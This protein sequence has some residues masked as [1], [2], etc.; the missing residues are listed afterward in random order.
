MDSIRFIEHRWQTQ[1]PKDIY[2]SK[3]SFFVLFLF[4]VGI[5]FTCY[6]KWFDFWDVLININNKQTNVRW[7]IATTKN[8]TFLRCAARIGM[9][10]MEKGVWLFREQVYQWF[11]WNFGKQETLLIWWT[12]FWYSQ[13]APDPDLITAKKHDRHFNNLYSIFASSFFF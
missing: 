2:C 12:Q 4:F 7:N 6:T 10:R 13:F 1:L 9:K 11:D 3:V 5:S 8:Y